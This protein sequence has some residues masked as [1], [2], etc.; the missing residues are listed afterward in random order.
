MRKAKLVRDWGD[1]PETFWF[2]EATDDHWLEVSQEPT[3]PEDIQRIADIYNGI[4]PDTG[5]QR[6]FRPITATTRY[7]QM[8]GDEV[9]ISDI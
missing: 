6:K 9:E 4:D 3:T 7:L 5:E 2:A 1:G 8:T